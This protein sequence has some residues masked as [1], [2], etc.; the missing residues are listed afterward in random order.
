MRL[1]GVAGRRRVVVSDRWSMDEVGVTRE[2]LIASEGLSWVYEVS[3]VPELQDLVA[4]E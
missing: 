2:K 1:S 4:D 3:A